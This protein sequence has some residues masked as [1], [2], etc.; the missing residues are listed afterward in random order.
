MASCIVFHTVRMDASCC[1]RVQSVIQC[2]KPHNIDAH[3]VP[4]D[5]AVTFSKSQQSI[6]LLTR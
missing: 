1:A 2:L 4:L 6:I 3:N 5:M